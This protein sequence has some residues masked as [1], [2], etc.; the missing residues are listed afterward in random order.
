[1]NLTVELSM[2]R[3]DREIVESV[4]E[5]GYLDRADS[6]LS[7][8]RKGLVNKFYEK[9][10]KLSRG[11]IELLTAG[12]A[13]N[14]Q[15]PQLEATDE[16]A[17]SFLELAKDES[18]LAY[19]LEKLDVQK[20][21]MYLACA[22]MEASGFRILSKKSDRRDKW[23][24]GMAIQYPLALLFSSNFLTAETTASVEQTFNKGACAVLHALA[25]E[26]I[27]SI[28]LEDEIPAKNSKLKLVA[29]RLDE[30]RKNRLEYFITQRLGMFLREYQKVIEDRGYR[31]QHYR[32]NIYGGLAEGIAG[33]IFATVP[34]MVTDTRTLNKL[35]YG[36]IHFD[37]A[38][39]V[40]Q[41]LVEIS[42]NFDS[43]Q[44][45]WRRKPTLPNP[46][47]FLTFLRGKFKLE[48]ER[49]GDQY[50]KKVKNESKTA[51]GIYYSPNE[52]R[53]DVEEEI[54]G[55]KQLSTMRFSTEPIERAQLI[56]KVMER[57]RFDEAR[58][59]VKQFQWTYRQLPD[60][61]DAKKSF[62]AM[63]KRLENNVEKACSLLIS[64][65]SNGH[66]ER[67]AEIRNLAESLY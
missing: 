65:K 8:S 44:K 7:H 66:H 12:Y 13:A 41:E 14:L 2:L 18:I 54:D 60:D 16:E 19:Y 20:L 11:D 57:F 24:N 62:L 61:Y 49:L 23:L 67:I 15:L 45:T 21:R 30:S 33:A 3:I 55:K 4:V 22:L 26:N 53:I 39:H 47:L 59:F 40:I 31:L 63:A 50:L 64:E 58:T 35:E 51:K 9:V 17:S 56:A 27:K 34:V 1:M 29:K 43:K 5:K 36:I 10:S 52:I 42:G 25:E 6:F 48:L 46:S 32:A 38:I 37:E 28:R